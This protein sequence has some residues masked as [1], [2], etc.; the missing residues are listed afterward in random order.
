M[1][2]DLPVLFAIRL[3]IVRFEVY[4]FCVV[5][6]L[7]ICQQVTPHFKTVVVRCMTF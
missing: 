7:W 2:V 6:V 5:H 4:E 3:Q 1:L